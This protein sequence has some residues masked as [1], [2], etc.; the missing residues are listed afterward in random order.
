MVQNPEEEK[1]Q[2]LILE[3]NYDL[4]KIVANDIEDLEMKDESNF[5]NIIEKNFNYCENL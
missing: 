4:D 2:P 1:D 5:I 3:K